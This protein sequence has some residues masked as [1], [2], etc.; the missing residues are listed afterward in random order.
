[1][2]GDGV[3]GPADL[4]MLLGSWGTCSPCAGP[5]CP[6]DIAGCDGVVNAADLGALLGNWGACDSGGGESMSEPQ[7]SFE[8]IET[9]IEYLHSIGEHELAEQIAALI[10]S[11]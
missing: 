11:P 4:G 6:A 2:N 1:M 8:S 7:G 9:F 3:V 10:E 5:P